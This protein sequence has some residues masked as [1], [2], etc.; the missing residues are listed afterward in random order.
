MYFLI[1]TTKINRSKSSWPSNY[2]LSRSWTYIYS[3]Q[4]MDNLTW[5]N[6]KKIDLESEDINYSV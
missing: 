1:D 6:G 3:F 4:S 2:C 5:S